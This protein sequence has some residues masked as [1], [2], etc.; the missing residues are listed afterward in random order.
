[1]G[2]GSSPKLVWPK[3][4]LEPGQGTKEPGRICLDH[5][6]RKFILPALARS[7]TLYGVLSGTHK[8]KLYRILVA[9]MP[10]VML[11]NTH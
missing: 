8:S 4:H 1:M 2:G 9:A 6:P 3:R 5:T 7:S 10:S 11:G